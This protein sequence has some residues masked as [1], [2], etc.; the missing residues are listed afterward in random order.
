KGASKV[1]AEKTKKK[2]KR[3]V[4]GDASGHAFPPKKLR[5]D[6]HAGASGMGGKSFSTICELVSDGFSI[7]S[8][9]TGPTTVV[10]MPH[11]PDDGQTNSLSGPNLHTCPPSLR[12]VVSSDDSHRSY[13]YFEF[14]SF[15]RSPAKDAPVTTVVVTT[16]VTANASI[17]PPPKVRVVS[18]A[19]GTSKLNEPVDSSNSFYAS[20][21]LDSDTLHR[22]YVPKWNVTNDSVLDDQ[23]VCRDLTDRLAPPALFAQLHVTTVPLYS[24]HT[25]TLYMRM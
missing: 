9:V 16:T 25:I 18:D 20:Q 2:Q 13:S 14:K 17:V 5:K 10:S 12:Y 22:I 4:V 11:T 1:V 15:A 19:T 3:K 7:S 23:Y 6:Y 8:G 21:D 24:P